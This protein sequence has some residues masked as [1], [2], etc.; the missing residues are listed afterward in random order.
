VSTRKVDDLVAALGVESGM[1]KSE[2]GRICGR[3]DTDITARRERDLAEQTT[4]YVFLDA[5]Y[6]WAESTPSSTTH[7]R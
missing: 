4:P 5:T 7:P 3:L 2:V 1:S 6:R